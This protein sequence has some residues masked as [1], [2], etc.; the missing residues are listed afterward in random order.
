MLEGLR[1]AASP[2]LGE[3]LVARRIWFEKPFTA[4]TVRVMLLSVVPAVTG[5]RLELL[6]ERVKS[7]LS[8]VTVRVA[9]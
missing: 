3:T 5:P 9:E 8:T 7:L 4:L 6:T 2:E 1:L